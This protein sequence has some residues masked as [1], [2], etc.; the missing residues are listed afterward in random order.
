MWRGG[1]ASVRGRGAC[2]TRK[3]LLA[4]GALE[5]GARALAVLAGA[6]AAPLRAAVATVLVYGETS[7]NGP[8]RRHCRGVDLFM[9]VVVATTTED[10]IA[11]ARNSAA[12]AYAVDGGRLDAIRAAWTWSAATV[13]AL[14]TW[15]RNSGLPRKGAR[16]RSYTSAACRSFCSSIDRAKVAIASL[17][18]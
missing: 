14:P 3:V 10:A 1:C 9:M 11:S 7:G 16:P 12:Q 2:R 8:E 17:L 4:H 5:S 13:H 15:V 18:A 6:G